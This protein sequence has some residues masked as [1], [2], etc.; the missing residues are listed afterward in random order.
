ML[1]ATVAETGNDPLFEAL[2]QIWQDVAPPHYG[3]IVRTFYER[4]LKN[5]SG[6]EEQPNGPRPYAGGLLCMGGGGW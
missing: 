3:A 6:E 5:V 4:H 1:H 2:R